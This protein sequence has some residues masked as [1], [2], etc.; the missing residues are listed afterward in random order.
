MRLARLPVRQSRRSIEEI[1]RH[2]LR[3]TSQNDNP[4]GDPSIEKR[5]TGWAFYS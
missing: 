1:S 2:D 4:P 5:N 3:S